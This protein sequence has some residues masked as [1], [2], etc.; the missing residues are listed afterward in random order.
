MREDLKKRKMQMKNL[1]DGPLVEIIGMPP[2]LE[3]VAT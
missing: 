3:K 1:S 2:E